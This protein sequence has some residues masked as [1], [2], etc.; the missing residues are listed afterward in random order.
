ME[1]ISAIVKFNKEFS[2]LGISA[3]SVLDVPVDTR[4]STSTDEMI[5][6]VEDEIENLFGSRLYVSQGD[7]SINNLDAIVKE[8]YE[9]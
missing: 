4:Y 1:Q 3:G 6:W 7:I 2:D 8:T 5:V 9:V